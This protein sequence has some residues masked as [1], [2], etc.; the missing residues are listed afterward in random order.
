M[1]MKDYCTN[2][3]ACRHSLLL[4]YF[5][6][7][8]AGGHCGQACDN[9]LARHMHSPRQDTVWQVHLSVHLLQACV[10]MSFS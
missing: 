9:C 6:E 4:D 1:Q 5:G 7:R 10:D 8:F 2:D 3:K